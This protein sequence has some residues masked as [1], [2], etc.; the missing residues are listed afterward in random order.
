[1]NT[2]NNETT[3]PSISFDFNGLEL[4][5]V[6][7]NDQPWFFAK[8]LAVILGHK[9]SNRITRLLP[10]KCHA[11]HKVGV[12]ESTGRYATKQVTLISEPGLYRAALKSRS[13]IAEDFTDWITEEVIPSIRKR[14]MYLR[15]QNQIRDDVLDTLANSLHHQVI[16]ALRE[17]DHLTEHDHWYAWKYS[18]KAQ[19]SH[20]MAVMKVAKKYDLAPS[21]VEAL[22]KHGASAVY[23]ETK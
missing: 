1:M 21:V 12:M 8:D 7:I 5:A 15:G 20:D 4:N 13:E 17:Y 19:R 6:L 22:T 11:P 2:T 16:P 14:G 10:E 18:D 23:K 3:Q 9:D